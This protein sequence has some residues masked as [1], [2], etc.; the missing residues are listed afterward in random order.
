MYINTALVLLEID[1][2]S[3]TSCTGDCLEVTFPAL[4]QLP[5][6]M[7]H[8]SVIDSVPL[9]KRLLQTPYT[10]EATVL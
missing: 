2:H 7:D 8:A 1:Y 5:C 9:W 4:G 6:P 10:V 3:L